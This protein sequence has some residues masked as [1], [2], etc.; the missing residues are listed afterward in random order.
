MASGLGLRG[1][2]G[3]CFL[4]YQDFAKCMKVS[5]TPIA[6][7]APLRDDYLECLHHRKELARKQ[8]IEEEATLQAKGGSHSGHGHSPH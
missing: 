5:D 4:F 1:N 7:C 2:I 8:A 3:R 6:D